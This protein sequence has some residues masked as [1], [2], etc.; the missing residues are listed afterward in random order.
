[1]SVNFKNQADEPQKLQNTGGMLKKTCELSQIKSDNPNIKTHQTKQSLSS[2][3]FDSLKKENI[4]LE[5]ENKVS[6]M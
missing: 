6:E 4:F 3:L 2:N 5:E 1:M